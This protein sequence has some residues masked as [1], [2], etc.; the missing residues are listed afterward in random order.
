MKNNCNIFCKKYLK[1]AWIGAHFKSLINLYFNF[2]LWRR[3][4]YKKYSTIFVQRDLEGFL[5]WIF[6]SNFY[7]KNSIIIK[8]S[9][10]ICQTRESSNLL[11]LFFNNNFYFEI[12]IFYYY[13]ERIII[14]ERNLFAR[15]DININSLYDLNDY[16]YVIK[17]F[18]GRINMRYRRI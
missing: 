8:R 2:S 18:N 15:K 11:S 16:Y 1:R 17:S 9:I 12:A 14:Y 6:Y 7:L 4:F 3:D 13:L 10:K 5:P